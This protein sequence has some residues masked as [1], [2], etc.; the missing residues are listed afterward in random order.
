M[1][2]LVS[3]FLSSPSV[4]TLAQPNFLLLFSRRSRPRGSELRI[5]CGETAR[6]CSARWAQGGE[7]LYAC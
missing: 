6:V 3:W 5:R 7:E 4:S 1:G 2:G